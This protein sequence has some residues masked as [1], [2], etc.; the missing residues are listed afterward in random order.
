MKA[1]MKESDTTVSQAVDDAYR[2][3]ILE[4]FARTRRS[5]PDDRDTWFPSATMPCGLESP[6]PPTIVGPLEA[7]AG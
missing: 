5:T 6:S 3:A 1:H 2:G 4:V 7:A